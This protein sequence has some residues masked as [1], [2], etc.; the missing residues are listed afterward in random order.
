MVMK[1]GGIIGSALLLAALQGC[2]GNYESL[3]QDVKRLEK[4]LSDVRSFQAEQTSEIAGLQ[5]ELRNLAGRVEEI[6][7]LQRARLGSDITELRENLSSLKRRVPPPAIVPVL[8]LESDEVL[9]KRL[10]NTEVGTLFSQALGKIREG[11]FADALSL[12]QEAYEKN[13]GAEGTPEIV[14]W[15]G[16]SYEGLGDNRKALETYGQLVTSWRDHP[17]TPLALLRQGSVFIRIGDFRTAEMA[18]RKLIGEYPKSPEAAQAQE[19]L[20][21]LK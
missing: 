10:A 16:I 6:E 1:T 5:T 13:Y 21:D 9:A 2:A 11:Q 7:H 19:R 17:R 18:F 8:T 14:F 12:L 15:R 3:R 4:S 20:K